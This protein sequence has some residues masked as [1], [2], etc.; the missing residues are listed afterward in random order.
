MRSKASRAY[1][2]PLS[3]LTAIMMLIYAWYGSIQSEKKRLI[4]PIILLFS[5]KIRKVNFEGSSIHDL[6]LLYYY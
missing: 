3:S 4:S 2:F 6:W 5:L 1:P